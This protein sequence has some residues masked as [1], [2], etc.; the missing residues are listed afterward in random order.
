MKQTQL[1][2]LRKPAD[3][4][5]EGS[6]DITITFNQH[7]HL[8]SAF[9]KRKR[10]PHGS[11]SHA[12]LTVWVRPRE[13]HGSRNVNVCPSHQRLAPV[14]GLDPIYE[15]LQK[16]CGRAAAS[17]STASL[18]H[19]KLAPRSG[20]NRVPNRSHVTQISVGRIN[21]R[22]I[23]FVQ[24]HTPEPVV[25]G[26]ARFMQL[27]PQRIGSLPRIRSGSVWEPSRNTHREDAAVNL[28]QRDFHGTTSP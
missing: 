25:F 14:L 16:Q 3:E 21:L 1:L 28:S 20:G 24:R 18:F 5:N 22:S 4:F 7:P 13:F 17:R 8:C 27:I 12:L 10:S 15:C 2:R 6:A 26:F 23:F 19:I 11:A 9:R